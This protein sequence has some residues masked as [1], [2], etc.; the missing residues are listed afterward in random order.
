MTNTNARDAAL[1]NT[2]TRVIHTSHQICHVIMFYDVIIRYTHRIA[3]FGVLAMWCAYNED[4]LA[5]ESWYPR[6]WCSE[7]DC[8][9]N[10]YLLYTESVLLLV[11]STCLHNKNMGEIRKPL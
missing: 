1:T 3:L 6:C 8:A 2:S 10:E 5:G 9:Y 4:D 11:A 7:R